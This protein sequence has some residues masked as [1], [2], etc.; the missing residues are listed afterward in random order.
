MADPSEQFSG[1]ISTDNDNDG[2]TA[3]FEH[4]L[5]TSDSVP[6]ESGFVVDFDGSQIT[7]SFPRNAL[8]SDVSYTV[9]VSP[10]LQTWTADGV[11]ESQDSNTATYVFE[12]EASQ[13]QRFFVRLRVEQ[14]PVLQQ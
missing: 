14:V 3:L 6:N 11:L 2:L 4:A 7:F 13:N 12:P 9:E 5:G 8:A 1:D 10:D